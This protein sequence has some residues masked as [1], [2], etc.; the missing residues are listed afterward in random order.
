MSQQIEV[1]LRAVTP[2]FLNGADNQTPELRAPS[3]RGVLRFWLRAL[4]GAQVG[5]NT[6]SLYARESRVFGNTTT[7]SPVV[8]RVSA[9]DG[10][11]ISSRRMLP[12]STQKDFANRAIEE[13]SCIDLTLA[14]RIGMPK[15]PD[16]AL[17]ALLMLISF[18]GV[19]KRSRRGFGSLQPIDVRASDLPVDVNTLLSA[20]PADGTALAAH[21]GQVLTRAQ[22]LC[23]G[24]GGGA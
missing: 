18:G 14:S 20:T 13:R 8:V 12:H 17:A 16:E 1:T 21:L 9:P 24:T 11:A 4:L 2:L 6:K 22:A 15:I 3:F 19:G 23:G 10:L 7:G 5:D